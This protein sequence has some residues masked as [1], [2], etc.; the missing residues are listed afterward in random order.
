MENMEEYEFKGWT[1]TRREFEASVGRAVSDAEWVNA[2][3]DLDGRVD[4]F[5]DELFEEIVKDT[6]QGYLADRNL[7]LGGEG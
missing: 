1:L 3:E 7:E 6:Q 4:N 5:V 2:C